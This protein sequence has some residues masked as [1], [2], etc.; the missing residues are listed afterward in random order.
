MKT[1]FATELSN[2]YVGKWIKIFEYKDEW[3]DIELRT[4]NPDDCYSDTYFKQIS[5]THLHG[6]E[7][8]IVLENDMCLTIDKYEDFEL[9]DTNPEIDI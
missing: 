4:N 1:N 8:E 2:H 6:Y 3:D 5:D 7:L 9:L